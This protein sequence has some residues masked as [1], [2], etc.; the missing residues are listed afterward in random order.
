MCPVLVLRGHVYTHILTHIH[1]LNLTFALIPFA[2]RIFP[3]RKLVMRDDIKYSLVF[4][5][6]LVCVVSGRLEACGQA[7][8]QQG[9]EGIKKFS[10]VFHL[11]LNN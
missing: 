3:T 6:L 11:Q 4:K 9:D 1:T 2:D 5:V 10:F 7:L 8:G